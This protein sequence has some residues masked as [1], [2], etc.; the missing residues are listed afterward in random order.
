MRKIIISSQ[1]T[2]NSID[3]IYG[4]E[5]Q[6]TSILQGTLISNIVDIKT[7]SFETALRRQSAGKV[8]ALCRLRDCKT[9]IK[10]FESFSST[11]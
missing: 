10:Q 11:R 5:E 7:N 6:A 2:P 1:I 4:L 8:P 9:F 3:Y